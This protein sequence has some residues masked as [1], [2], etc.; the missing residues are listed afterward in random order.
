MNTG[1]QA[2]LDKERAM[3]RHLSNDSAED[4][5]NFLNSFLPKK[6]DCEQHDL[7]ES[8][9]QMIGV[10]INCLV[11]LRD[12]GVVEMT[13]HMIRRSTSSDWQI[14]L[15]DRDISDTNKANLKNYLESLGY[16]DGEVSEKQP[17]SFNELH[18]LARSYWGSFNAL[19]ESNLLVKAARNGDLDRIKFLVAHGYNLESRDDWGCTALHRAAVEGHL[20][21][22]AYLIDHGAIIESENDR[23]DYF[24]RNTGDTC[25]TGNCTSLF[26]AAS[27]G[28]L[29][30]LKLLIDRGADIHREDAGGLTPIY[31]TTYNFGSDCFECMRY[32]AGKGANIDVKDYRDETM[33]H[34][35][36]Y[37]GNEDQVEYLLSLGVNYH[38]M[39]RDGLTALDVAKKEKRESIVKIIDEFH[40]NKTED[41][42]LKSLIEYHEYCFDEVD[43]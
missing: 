39:T 25:K 1:I 20:D 10:S 41:E 15:L 32:L 23:H 13:P 28:Q 4:L 35:S 29:A 14:E 27:Q 38:A 6:E 11:E 16:I 30:C 26:L 31:Y 42:N 24:N 8:A 18:N 37:H 9:I 33:L 3:L 22:M 5:T 43:I 34:S 2:E 19:S 17:T 12:N 7:L 40:R 21:C 36:A